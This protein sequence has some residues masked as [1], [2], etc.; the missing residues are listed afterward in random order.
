MWMSWRV[1]LKAVVDALIIGL[2]WLWSNYLLAQSFTVTN[3]LLWLIA[4]GLLVLCSLLASIA[5]VSGDIYLEMRDE[6][7]ISVFKEAGVYT[8]R[9]ISGLLLLLFISYLFLPAWRNGV[10]FHLGIL[11]FVTRMLYIIKLVQ[12]RWQ[13]MASLDLVELLEIQVP[14]HEE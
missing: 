4:L 14:Q 12:L 7:Q 9:I 8:L 3:L 1:T 2:P 6:F 11:L 13:D 5:F 10:L